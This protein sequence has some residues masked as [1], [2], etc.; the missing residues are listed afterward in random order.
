[1]VCLKE[2]CNLGTNALMSFA[3]NQCTVSLQPLARLTLERHYA[4]GR[5][6]GL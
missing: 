2:S 1:M 4:Y 6:L 5:D 3:I